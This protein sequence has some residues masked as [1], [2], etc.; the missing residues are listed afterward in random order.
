MGLETNRK[1]AGTVKVEV[2]IAMNEPGNPKEREK[3]GMILQSAA[4]RLG[5]SWV[6]P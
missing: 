2:M 3:Q 4:E 6:R 5:R 1:T